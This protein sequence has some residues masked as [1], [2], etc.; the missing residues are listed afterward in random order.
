MGRSGNNPGYKVFSISTTIRNPRRNTEFLEVLKKFDNTELTSETKNEIYIELIRQ[1]IYKVNN[2]DNLIKEK[3]EQNILLTDEEINKIIKENPQ[4]TGDEGRLMTQIRALKDTGLVNLIGSRNKKTLQITP[5]GY[6]LLNNDNIDDVYSKAMIGL[7]ANNPQRTTIYNK[8]RPF[9]NTLFVI[10]EVNKVLGNDKGILWHEF[11]VFV[12]SMKD[13]DYKTTA[14]YIIENRKK[15]K[16]KINQ[17]YLENYLYQIVK[18]NS[19]K[20]NSILKDYADDVYRKFDMT[21]LID[22][23]GFGNN[24]YVRFDKYNISKV[25]SIL[26]YYSDYKYTEFEN[27]EKYTDYLTEIVLPWEKS[28]YVKRQIV[29]DKKKNLNVEINEN[30]SLDNQ[31]KELDSI[32]NKRIFENFVDNIKMDVI[33]KELILL[34]R[35]LGEKSEFN[36]IPEPVR[37][38]WFIALITAKVYGAKYVKPNLTLDNNGVPK[39]HAAGGL[40]DIEFIT[41][42]LYCLIEVTLQRDYKQQENNETTSISDHLRELKSNKEKCSILIAP[43]IHNRVV[44]YFQYCTI[45]SKLTILATTI[46]LYI[47]MIEE[48]KN[49]DEFKIIID[50]MTKKMIEMELKDYCDYI[51]NYH[52]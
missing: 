29:E 51:N 48:S 37:L 28:D 40:A 11:A 49:I 19:V 34:S 30:D 3:Y 18:V 7:H 42:E 27:T 25:K 1:G 13:C 50:K 12:L 36:S 15:N 24:T 38:E 33:K 45:R 44:D 20:F 14:Q 5:L 32:N 2:L 21:G 43:R 9:L 31:I 35:N 17:I 4:K 26:N 16:N 47:E 8:S 10:N 52:I 41:E 22:S 23:S 6:K 39:S 46:E